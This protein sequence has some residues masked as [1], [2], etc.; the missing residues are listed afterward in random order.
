MSLRSQNRSIQQPVLREVRQAKDHVYM[1]EVIPTPRTDAVV[2][3]RRHDRNAPEIWCTEDVMEIIKHAR[4]LERE[5]SKKR[6]TWKQWEGGQYETSCD[7]VFEFTHNGIAENEAVFCQYCGG[8]I[9]E[10][11]YKEPEVD[12][13]EELGDKKRDHDWHRKTE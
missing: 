10:V 1:Q 2:E 7:H 11:P 12:H 4:V 9:I 3:A 5:L 8:V 13:A 6:C